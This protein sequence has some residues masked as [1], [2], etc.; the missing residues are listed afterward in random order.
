MKIISKTFRF[1]Q[2]W[3]IM[4]IDGQAF[5]L[6]KDVL[7]YFGFSHKSQGTVKNAVQPT[8]WKIIGGDDVKVIKNVKNRAL[9]INKTGLM[10]FVFQK[11]RG[12]Q[13]E[14]GMEFI[15]FVNEKV[16]ID[17]RSRY[18]KKFKL[19]APEPT[20]TK[21]EEPKQKNLIDMAQD[22]EFQEMKKVMVIQSERIDKLEKVVQELKDERM[23]DEGQINGQ[24]I[25]N[26][27]IEKLKNMTQT[28]GVRG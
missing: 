28:N 25:I 17:L 13:K 20:P 23:V 3:E 18:Y 15:R 7:N 19:F 12:E 4:M 14:K 2:D 9:I 8:D 16:M 11:L 10:D 21:K 24:A 27:F 26:E 6:V 1:K 5:F 22:M